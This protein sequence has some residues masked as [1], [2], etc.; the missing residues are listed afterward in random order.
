MK[1]RR[2]YLVKS[3]LDSLRTGKKY[4]SKHETDDDLIFHHGNHKHHAYGERPG[5]FN[6]KNIDGF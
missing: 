6:K 3:I 1:W 2:L 4:N 5:K